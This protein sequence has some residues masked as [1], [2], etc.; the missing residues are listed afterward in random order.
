MSSPA[1]AEF[2]DVLAREGEL[3]RIRA[4]V[5]AE[6]ELAAI[7]ERTVNKAGPALLFERVKGQSLP[8]V[9]NLLGSERRTCLALGIGSLAEFS[10]RFEQLAEADNRPGWW[11]RLKSRGAET[12]S[13]LDRFTPRTIKAG[14]CQQIVKLGRDVDLLRLPALRSWP[15][16][17]ARCITA[18]Q[19]LAIDPESARTSLSNSTLVILD[20]AR[21]GIPWHPFSPLWRMA[22]LAKLRGE[23]LP[24]AIVLGGSLAISIFSRLP[25]EADTNL[26]SLAGLWNGTALN[27]VRCRTQ[28]LD[29]PAEA[30]MIIEGYLDPSAETIELPTFV[31]SSGTYAENFPGQVIEVT[32]LTHRSSAT[33]P[34]V[35][36]QSPE[37]ELQSLGRL[38]ERLLLPALQAVAS[39]IVDLS[40]PNYGS[41]NA[42]VFVSLRQPFPGAARRVANVVWGHAALMLAKTI[43]LVD[44]SVNVHQSAEVSQ[45]V[46]AHA[47]PQRDTFIQ[48]GPCDPF[49][50]AQA[51]SQPGVSFAT[52][53]K[54][55]IDATSKLTGTIPSPHGQLPLHTA[56]TQLQ[57]TRRWEELGLNP[58]PAKP[59][60][61]AK[62]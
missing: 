20:R 19:V 9:A 58:A 6:L 54:L 21:L 53:S 3:L 33:W 45:Q 30:E 16:E 13:P 29:V 47:D 60:K 52:G 28:P 39:E 23:K 46:A 7:V 42:F 27:V 36:Y 61:K 5:D 40:L 17:V 34:A 51:S 43:V 59:G 50:F 31:T 32:A 8:V 41:S 18:G 35:V 14:V 4:E 37:C 26:L 22:D 1:L 24:V 38:A 49:D 11:E 57:L 10:T 48:Q 56:E 44:E 12:A 15:Q 55:G 2:M 25:F 62:A